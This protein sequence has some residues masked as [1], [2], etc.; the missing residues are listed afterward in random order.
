MLKIEDCPKPVV[1]AIHGT[2]FGGGLEV[3]MACH[4]RVAVPSA[5]VGQPEVKLGIIPGA[6]GTQRLPR[7]A[8]V[9]KALEMCALGDPVGRPTSVRGRHRG[10]DH[11][12]RPAAGAL[13][14]AR[15][16]RRGERPRKTRDRNEKLGDQGER[17]RSSTRPANWPQEKPAACWRRQGHRRRRSR[18]EAP[19]RGGLQARGELFQECLFSDQSKAM[20]HVFFGEREVAKIPGSPKT[21]V[22]SSKCGGRRRGNHGRRHRDGLRECWNSGDPQGGRPGGFSIAGWRTSGGTTSFGQERTLHPGNDGPADGSDP[23]HSVT[24]VSRRRTSS[25]KPSSKAWR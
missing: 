21:P 3:A 7:L 25:S 11:R 1:A 12:R 20:I 8:G 5:Q 14:F 23:A 6:A 15:E 16:G 18:H 17:R 19:L 10:P 13:A 24:T 4:Y 9:A 2:A 22:G